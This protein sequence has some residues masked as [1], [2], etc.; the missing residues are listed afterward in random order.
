[1]ALGSASEN[2][3]NM[4]PIGRQRAN[5]AASSQRLIMSQSFVA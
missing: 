2:K 1:M 4:T 5:T 3:K